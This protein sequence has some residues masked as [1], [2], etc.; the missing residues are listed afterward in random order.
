MCSDSAVIGLF[1][2]SC[3]RRHGANTLERV[4]R[5]PGEDAH[6]V[7]AWLKHATSGYIRPIMSEFSLLMRV[8]D[9]SLP[10]RDCAVN[11]GRGLL[12]S[13]SS[14][15]STVLADAVRRGVLAPQ[16]CDVHEPT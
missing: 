5:R 14:G 7:P 8:N 15:G 3:I 9:E 1:A 6:K 10:Q 12:A 4:G 2:L 11:V 13:V 16:A